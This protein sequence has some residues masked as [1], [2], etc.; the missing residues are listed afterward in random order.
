LVLHL[1]TAVAALR[2]HGA[3]RKASTRVRVRG[4]RIDEVDVTNAEM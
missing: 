4:M 2:D 1:N 3:A